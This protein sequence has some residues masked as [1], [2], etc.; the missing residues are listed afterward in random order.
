MPNSSFV[1][2]FEMTYTGEVKVKADDAAEA[3]AIVTEMAKHSDHEA[4]LYHKLTKKPRIRPVEA[5]VLSGTPGIAPAPLPKDDYSHRDDYYKDETVSKKR[6]KG[7]RPWAKGDSESRPQAVYRPKPTA[8][9]I[10]RV[11]EERVAQR[12]G[13]IAHTVQT[14]PEKGKVAL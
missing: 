4:V 3:L 14:K 12:G 1:V 13:A 2:K 10:A 6:R 5:K 9:E 7:G 8:E 11:E